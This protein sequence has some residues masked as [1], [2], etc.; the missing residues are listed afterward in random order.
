MVPYLQPSGQVIVWTWSCGFKVTCSRSQRSDCS[1]L[2]FLFCFSPSN[3]LFFVIDHTTKLGMKDLLKDQQWWVE[4]DSNLIPPQYRPN[5]LTTTPCSPLR[6]APPYAMLPLYVSHVPREKKPWWLD[7]SFLLVFFV[8]FAMTINGME[9]FEM[10]EI[11]VL[12]EPIN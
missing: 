6:H 3:A 7:P 5:A 1:P 2:L 12:F 8:R 4:R 10:T 9:L 11:G